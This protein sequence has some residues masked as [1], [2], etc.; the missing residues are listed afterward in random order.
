MKT[1]KALL[2]EITLKYKTGEHVKAKVSSSQDAADILIKT[3]NQDMIE[4][5]EEF[6]AIFL[7][8]ASNT[9][10]W[11]RVSTGGLS[12][13]VVDP[14]LIFSTALKCLAS[15]VIL[16]HNHPSG[17]IKPSAADIAMTKKIVQGGSLLD[18]TIIDH[19]I[20][21]LDSDKKGIYYSFADEGQL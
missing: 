19:L 13:T 14:K 5:Q 9:I 20:V 10:G 16:A 11:M 15:G 12:A 4:A 3:F 1:Y 21:A 6:I 7:N 2:P 8:R 18:I 17:E